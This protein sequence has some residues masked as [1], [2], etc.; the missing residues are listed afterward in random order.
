M[1]PMGLLPLLAGYGGVTGLVWLGCLL[2]RNAPRE[3]LPQRLLLI[4]TGI[5]LLF[6]APPDLIPVVIAFAIFLVP[7]NQPGGAR[8]KPMPSPSASLLEAS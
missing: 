6:M 4:T 2:W 5:V 3:G 1:E 7:R 8:Q